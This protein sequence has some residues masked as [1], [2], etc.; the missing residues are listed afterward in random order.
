MAV[1]AVCRSNK[2]GVPITV[3]DFGT[4]VR[5]SI[6]I[7]LTGFKFDQT[8]L[9]VVKTIS[10]ATEINLFHKCCQIIE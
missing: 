7:A 5:D 10:A 9:R 8:I 3:Q 4:E 2:L 6:Q 1:V